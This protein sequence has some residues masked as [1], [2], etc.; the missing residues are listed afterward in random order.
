[1]LPLAAF[2]R[3]NSPEHLQETFES[4]DGLKIPPAMSNVTG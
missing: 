2:R 1:M 3:A 4:L